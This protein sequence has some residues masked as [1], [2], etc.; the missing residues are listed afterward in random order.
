MSS[1]CAWLSQEGAARATASP[2]PTQAAQM[3]QGCPAANRPRNLNMRNLSRLRAVS[4]KR[5]AASGQPLTERGGP[6]TVYR[7]H[8]YGTGYLRRD[9]DT[10]CRERAA[11][12]GVG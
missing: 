7:S 12:R 3:S 11:A 8:V 9:K 10:G 4:T 6:R 1:S 2:R 5:T